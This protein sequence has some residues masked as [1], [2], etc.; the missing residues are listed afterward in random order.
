MNTFKSNQDLQ[1]STG[2]THLTSLDSLR[3]LAALYVLC[4]HAFQQAGLEGDRLPSVLQVFIKLFSYGHYAVDL[5]IVL[6]GF[7]LMLPVIRNGGK[8]RENYKQFCIKRAKRILPSYYFAMGLS[9]LLI[10]TCIGQ[11]TGNSWDL[12]LPVNSKDI[13]LHVLLIHDLLQDACLKINSA[14]WSI[15]VEWRIYFIFPLLVTGYRLWGGIKTT[16]I[17]TGVGY[18]AFLLI[19]KVSFLN[20]NPIGPCPHYL[21]LFAMGMLAADITFND[22]SFNLHL[23]SLPWTSLSF[24]FILLALPAY[25]LFLGGSQSWVISDLLVGVACMAMLVFTTL[26]HNHPVNKILGWKPLAKIGVFSYSLYLIHVPLLQVFIQYYLIPLKLNP[27]SEILILLGVALPMITGLAYFFF[28]IFEK[29]FMAK[30]VKK[31]EII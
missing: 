4:H 1:Q 14:F 2:S 11:Q 28:L 25:N 10:F 18:I 27:V 23:R 26:N 8:L 7:C 5:F 22:T 3:A 13:I 9:L 31:V 17:A 6:S 19:A 29:P 16:L 30:R 24:V 15:S 20:S 12:S 21:G